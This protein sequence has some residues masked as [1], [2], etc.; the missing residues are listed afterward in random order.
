MDG[1]RHRWKRRGGEPETAA[2]AM[3]FRGSS[4]PTR[5]VG[6]R[7]PTNSQKPTGSRSLPV[8]FIFIF[9][10]GRG[11]STQHGPLVTFFLS[12]CLG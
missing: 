12:T 1:D 4:G 11:V 10:G 5:A 3:Y 8:F 2:H 6:N 9:F 7:V